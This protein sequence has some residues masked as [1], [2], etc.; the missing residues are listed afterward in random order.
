MDNELVVL[1]LVGSPKA[2]TVNDEDSETK[3]EHSNVN[4]AVKEPTMELPINER[5]LEERWIAFSID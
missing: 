2:Q 4:D 1:E 5:E 3:D